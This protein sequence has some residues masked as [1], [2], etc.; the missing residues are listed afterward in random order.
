MKVQYFII[1]LAELLLLCP[2]YSQASCRCEQITTYSNGRR[3]CSCKPGY[4]VSSKNPNKCQDKDECKDSNQTICEHTC[5]NTIGSYECS[6]NSGYKANRINPN[7]CQDI[8]E[9]K[10]S[11]QT[12]CEHTC[13]NSI[14]SYECSCKSGYKVNLI[15]PNICQDVDECKD[16]NQTICEHTC[17]NTIGSY[18]CSCKSGYKTSSRDPK[19]CEDIDDCTNTSTPPCEQICTN[20]N[21]S[22]SCSC[23]PGYNINKTHANV[24]DRPC[25]AYPQGRNLDYAPTTHKIY[26]I[27][28]K[29]IQ[30]CFEKCVSNTSCYGYDY[31][32]GKVCRLNTFSG[33]GIDISKESD[34]APY[35]FCRNVTAQCKRYIVE[36]ELGTSTASNHKDC[37]T[38]CALHPK[39]FGYIYDAKAKQC[40][41]DIIS[42][43]ETTSNAEETTTLLIF[44]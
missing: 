14:G 3:V 15:N 20:T 28:V 23:Y 7:I 12:V 21:G 43:P 40:F 13:T 17:T 44:C 36:F 6:C 26:Y 27:F 38:D 41:Y 11:N 32:V 16:S 24:C 5:T 37:F 18:E 2:L 39:C 31:V 33:N 22:Y 1:I 9:C 10:D 30:D 8:D 19:K 34:A 4:V 35:M 25:T 29:K 42:G